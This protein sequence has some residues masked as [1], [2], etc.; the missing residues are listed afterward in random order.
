M[1][2]RYEDAKGSRCV[3]ESQLDDCIKLSERWQIGSCRRSCRS[4]MPTS[5][6][7]RET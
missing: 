5:C 1:C 2:N 6:L 3:V 4:L 7:S